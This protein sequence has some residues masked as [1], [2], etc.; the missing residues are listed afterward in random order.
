[1]ITLIM[2]AVTLVMAIAF[3]AVARRETGSVDQQKDNKTA[4]L[5][6]ETAVARAQAQI[7]ASMLASLK[8]NSLSPT[9]AVSTNAY[10]LHLFVS[11]NLIN[12]NGFQTGVSSPTNVNY[13]Y[14]NGRSLTPNDLAQN[15]AN[16]MILP[17]APVFV[18]TNASPAL[19]AY[20]FRFYL[21]LNEN[22]SFEP[23]GMQPVISE[24]PAEPYYNTNTPPQL[25]A[26]MSPGNVLSNFMVGD[27]EWVGILARPD[28]PHSALNPFL[29]RYAFIALPAGNAL[30][31]N[32]IHNEALNV[33][34][35]LETS[36]TF[37]RNQGVG[38]WELNLAAFLADLNT[39]VW[40]GPLSLP[41]PSYYEYD[42]PSGRNNR[43]VAFQDALS[44]VKWRYNTYPL[45]FA[46]RLFVN[47]NPLRYNNIDNTSRGPLQTTLD[48]YRLFVA[49]PVTTG[50][51]WSGADSTNHYFSLFDWLDGS[52]TGT[53][54]NSLTNRLRAVGANAFANRSVP[55]GVLHPTYDSYTFY[56][57]L[58]EM[59]SDSSPDDG[60][61][62]LNY[63]N[64]VV[65]ADNSGALHVN[66]IPGAETNLTRWAPT[67]FFLAAADQLLRTYSGFWYSN[68]PVAFASTYGVSNVIGFS[69]TNIP[70][71]VSN[72]FVYTP[73]I[74]RLLQLA[75]NIYDATTN[76]N[77]NLPH[78]YRPLFKVVKR[79]AN[80]VNNDVFI[81]GYIAVNSVSGTGDAQLAP[82]YDVTQLLRSTKVPISDANGPVNV[83]G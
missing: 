64:A 72:R 54:I 24:Y 20:D 1:M 65:Y 17:R 27:P 31:I 66:I 69:I 71:W 53:G 79:S 49:P 19:P 67:N 18:P 36:D 2:L 83:Y 80:G 25:Q 21:D 78:V 42:Q 37:M 63:S 26:T 29:A 46:N 35:T 73:A 33:G 11:T 34:T 74:H 5:A 50:V 45:P 76:N 56:R 68:S 41:N 14:H 52:K 60:R 62:N 13:Y 51:S 44:L 23:N 7:V 39:N 15:I 55:G 16:L 77:F 47:S 28:A 32:Y 75:A 3:L 81:T 9:N 61:L 12:P 43:G 38:S 8:T 59:A 58:D 4:Q 48:Y 57:M 40:S 22:G 6:A 30:D 70:V 10:N 82:P